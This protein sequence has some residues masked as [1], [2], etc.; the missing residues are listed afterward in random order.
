MTLV[1]PEMVNSEDIII[2]KTMYVTGVG[3]VSPAIPMACV[4]LDWGIIPAPDFTQVC[5][6]DLL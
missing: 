2:G 3:G 4:Y 1:C 5:G 6:T